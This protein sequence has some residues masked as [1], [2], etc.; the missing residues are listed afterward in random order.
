MSD[1]RSP[2]PLG[3]PIRPSLVLG[4]KRD[5]VHPREGQS[6]P[7]EVTPSL[8]LLKL[9]RNFGSDR[10]GGEEDVKSILCQEDG[11]A[12]SSGV[13][14]RSSITNTNNSNYVQIQ[15]INVKSFKS[16]SIA[17]S[18]EADKSFVE[19]VPKMEYEHID[20]PDS[21]CS[22]VSPVGSDLD[23]FPT[24]RYEQS[25]EDYVYPRKQK[26]V[27]SKSRKLTKRTCDIMKR[28]MRL[29]ATN[30]QSKQSSGF[31]GSETKVPLM[32]SSEQVAGSGKPSRGVGIQCQ[33]GLFDPAKA[34]LL[35]QMDVMNE[36]FMYEA[37]QH[38][39]SLAWKRRQSGLFERL[40]GQADTSERQVSS[41]EKLKRQANSPTRQAS[42][43]ERQ[44]SYPEMQENSSE[45]QGSSPE[46]QESSPERQ[47]SSPERHASSPVRKVS[48]PERLNASR[49][50]ALLN[51][52]NSSLKWRQLEGSSMARLR[53]VKKLLTDDHTVEIEVCGDG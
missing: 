1:N 24:Q 36:L 12:V 46:R 44:E 40:N 35:H 26:K 19:V 18:K 48:S 25:D 21:M 27:K 14:E 33:M 30:Q 22:G 50:I 28:K 29:A 38:I 10:V 34:E 2:D 37:Q 39:K 16:I 51:K 20:E 9:E 4:T 41:P 53:V 7:S 11:S 32:L 31:R 47:E 23:Y 49:N 3:T 5:F 45:R 15:T 6:R 13:P 43:P 8:L 17:A 42:S 52:Y